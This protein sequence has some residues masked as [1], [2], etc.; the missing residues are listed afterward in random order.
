MKKVVRYLAGRPVLFNA[1]RRLIEADY[2]SLKRA[3]KNEFSLEGGKEEGSA[4]ERI[5]DVPCGTG[6]FSML[7]PSD[8]YHG[9]DISKQYIDYARKKYDKKYFCRDARKTGFGPHYFD[10]ILMLGFLH[11]LDDSEVNSVLKEVKRILK[12][13]GMLLMIED[14]PT[15]SRWNIIGS[16]L[17]RLDIGSNIRTAVEYKSILSRY[18]LILRYYHVKSGFW[19]YSVFVLEPDGK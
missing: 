3:I 1:L 11:H 7:F 14:A 10:K 18:F 12:P 4:G 13:D 5:L 15:S 2:V 9:L 19:D 6:E 8:S 17:Q 16:F